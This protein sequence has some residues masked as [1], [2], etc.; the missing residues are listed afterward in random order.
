MIAARSCGLAAIAVPGT[1]AWRPTWARLLADRH[2]TIAMDCDEPGR[3]AAQR[4]SV[5]LQRVGAA[6]DVVD[7]W[8][9]RKDGYDITD[10]ILERRRT[11]TSARRIPKSV[12][13]L[14]EPPA[15]RPRA[16]L[17]QSTYPGSKETT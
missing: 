17:G 6:V 2:I 8:P 15:A 4:I 7:L 12:R 9:D 16:A 5:D 11:N 10:R 13:S 1:N 3:H 14:L